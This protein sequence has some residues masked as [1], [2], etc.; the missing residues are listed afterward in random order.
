MTTTCSGRE[1]ENGR[2][3]NIECRCCLY[4]GSKAG[5]EQRGRDQLH[6][7]TGHNVYGQVRL[8]VTV[9]ICMLTCIDK[10]R[11][12]QRL[13][14][15]NTWQKELEVKLT[16]TFCCS[17]MALQA[18]EQLSRPLVYWSPLPPPQQYP[19][20]HT[21]VHN[22]AKWQGRILASTVILSC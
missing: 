22:P 15:A 9:S 7:S 18:Q 16:W 4:K 11:T 2:V 13:N 6:C 19:C 14:M 20:S 10:K 3:A 12:W 1:A 8:C 21:L 5:F 17:S